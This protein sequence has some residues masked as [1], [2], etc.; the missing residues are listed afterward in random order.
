MRFIDEL[1]SSQSYIRLMMESDEFSMTFIK[2]GLMIKGLN[3]TITVPRGSYFYS[4]GSP[5]HTARC[6]WWIVRLIGR[7]LDDR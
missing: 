2:L 4:T 5:L 7:H 6:H 1:E 3:H